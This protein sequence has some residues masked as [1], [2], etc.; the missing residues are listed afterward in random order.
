MHEMVK[1]MGQLMQKGW[2]PLR[3]IVF[4]SWDVSASRETQG[5]FPRRMRR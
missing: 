1:A 3:T 2:K 4:A 5:R